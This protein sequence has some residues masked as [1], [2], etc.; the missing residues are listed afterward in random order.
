MTHMNRPIML[1][2]MPN[3]GS[4]WLADTICRSN[5]G[6]RYYREFFN[7][8]TNPKYFTVLR[9]AFGCEYSTCFA[10]IATLDPSACEAA[11]AASWSLESFDFTKENYSAFK[12][13]FL[14][15]KFQCVALIRKVQ[16]SLPA[17]RSVEVSMWYDAIYHSLILHQDQLTKGCVE[18]LADFRRQVKTLGEQ[19]TFVFQLYQFILEENCRK[20]GVP[21]L[22]HEVLMHAA[23]PELINY[24][25]PCRD[26]LDVG[27]L[28]QE[29]FTG[30]LQNDR[31][32]SLLNS[33]WIFQKYQWKPC[34]ALL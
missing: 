24:L 2:S 22:Q 14:A 10:N 8:G 18:V 26:F 30:R 9:Q 19:T 11:F 4:D 34:P 13:P 31:N 3:N 7:P 15:Q 17:K 29:I 25:Q 27:A 28:A 32:F 16:N 1:L 23:L 5:P 12:I 20:A 33:D 6:L 21:I